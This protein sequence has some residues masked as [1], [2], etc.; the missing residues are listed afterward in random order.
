[1][2]IKSLTQKVTKTL[3]NVA[4][5]KDNLTS[6]KALAIAALAFSLVAAPNM[7]HAQSSSDKI[8]DVGGAALVVGIFGW[9]TNNQNS[10]NSATNSVITAVATD[11]G[12]QIKGEIDSN[13]SRTRAAMGKVTRDGVTGVLKGATDEIGVT[14]YKK[15]NASTGNSSVG[16]LTAPELVIAGVGGTSTKKKSASLNAS[17]LLKNNKSSFFDKNQV[18]NFA[19]MPQDRFT[20][21]FNY[22]TNQAVENRNTASIA[23]LQ[24]LVD[25]AKVKYP[26]DNYKDAAIQALNN[27]TRLAFNP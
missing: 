26:N 16:G 5:L 6:T 12:N 23:N 3:S 14:S 11:A 2:S 22:Y 24:L 19:N 17:Q 20:E 9:L 13:S 10:I 21:T 1:M 18:E 7:A 15:K 8:K 27:G 4:E 25:I